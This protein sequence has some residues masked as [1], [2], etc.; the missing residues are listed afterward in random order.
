MRDNQGVSREDQFTCNNGSG[1]IVSGAASSDGMR[2]PLQS[3]QP[4]AL[5]VVLL[6]LVPFLTDLLQVML[7]LLLECFLVLNAFVRDEPHLRFAQ[8]DCNH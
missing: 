8:L 7:K 6:T 2:S 4:H 3:Q 1:L 5:S